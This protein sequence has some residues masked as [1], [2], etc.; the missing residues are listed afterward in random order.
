VENFDYIII[1]AGTAGCVLAERLSASGRDRVLVLEAGG[2]DSGFWIKT[3]I[4]YGRTFADPKVNWKYQTA[5]NPGL[6]GRTMY[7][8]RGR[9]VGGSSSINALVYC[10]GM[11]QDFDDW[12]QLGN[13]GWGWEDVRRYFEKSERRVDAAGRAHS[14]APLDVKDV[15]P[16]LHPMRANWLAAAAELHLPTT[17]D[18]NGPHPEGFGCYQISVRNG[19]RWSAADAFLRPALRHANARLDT[20]AWVSK[21]RFFERRALGVEYVREGVPGYATANRE[22]ILC[23]GSVNSPQLLQ[24]S[25]IG[26]A[27]AL[28]ALGIPALLDNG[29]VGGNL[30]DHLA[31]VY[32][33]KATR[34]TLN[35]ELHSVLGRLR[36]GLRYL[37]ARS[38][39]LSLSVNQFGAFL[40]ADPAALRPD[41]QVYC[42][43]VTYGAGDAARTRIEVDAFPGFYLCFQPTRPTSAG[44]IDIATADYRQPPKIAPNYLAT[45][46]DLHDVMHGGRLMQAIAQTRAMQELIQEP[47]AP[48]LM[49]MGP[50]ELLADFRARAATVYHPVG[51]CRM[52]K[53]PAQSVVDPQ[54][55]VHGVERLRVVDAS[56]FP[57]IT[58]ANTNAPTMMV[59][60]KA[61]DLIL[62]S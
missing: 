42:N 8:P 21:I 35:N 9:V 61:A 5:A 10:R 23:A 2:A 22:V 1:G 60:Q 48:D 56:V 47:I 29:A 39:P 43:P 36:N 49:S 16:F 55:R 15:T 18:F 46:K 31:V 24:L 32:S 40:R 41:V 34:P 30:Q 25:G 38:G 26:D 51:T 4:G 28:R 19:R 37:L 7:W 20:N 33:F 11:P 62:G 59:A 57:A 53:D 6:G 50:A 13:V 58:S 14:D 12:R 3:P 54:L 52:G 17:E 27:R 45:D 44:R